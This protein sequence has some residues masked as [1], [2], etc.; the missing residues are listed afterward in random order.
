MSERATNLHIDVILRRP[1]PM[2]FCFVRSFLD[3]FGYHCTCTKV[4]NYAI[5]SVL[6]TSNTSRFPSPPAYSVS[7]VPKTSNYNDD[8]FDEQGF[9]SFAWLG[10]A[11]GEGVVRGSN[12]I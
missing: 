10:E 11:A 4:L 12:L 2:F 8:D 6:V 3:F 9:E 1:R 7:A 5:F